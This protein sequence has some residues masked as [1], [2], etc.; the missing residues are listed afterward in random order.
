MSAD[1][2][3]SM[4]QAIYPWLVAAALGAS[5]GLG[6]VL[7]TPAFNRLGLNGMIRL[8]VAFVIAIPV[9]PS[10]LSLVGGQHLSVLMTL[11][12]VAKEM[13]IGVLIGLVFGVP[14][15]AAEIA[16]HLI[17]L[18]RGS[19]MAQLL[20]PNAMTQTNVTATLMTVTMIAL[21]FASGGFHD[22]LQGFYQSYTFW[23]LMTFKPALNWPAAM[24][25]IGLLDQ[26]MVIGVRM[27]APLII[28]IL[29]ADL[30]LAY[31]ARIAPNLHVFAL[32]LPIK[33]LLFALLM[34]IYIMFLV[35]RMMTDL[36]ALSDVPARLQSVVGS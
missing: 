33:N 26:M 4:T 30:M 17:D 34:V 1:F 36:G 11:G 31:L 10:L 5:R 21:F 29:V 25:V 35:P 13:L 16:G 32:S 12:L 8:A 14:F 18:Q 9:V 15:W 6:I 19:S 2:I 20:D 27:M 7:V 3:H 22:L 23:P 28:A 24:A